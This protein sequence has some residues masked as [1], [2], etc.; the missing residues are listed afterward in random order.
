M[1][2]PISKTALIIFNQLTIF[3]NSELYHFQRP[4][5]IPSSGLRWSEPILLLPSGRSLQKILPS[6]EWYVILLTKINYE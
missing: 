4:G 1:I 3:F 6:L 2:K 5:P